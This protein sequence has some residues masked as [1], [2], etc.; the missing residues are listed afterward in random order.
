[1]STVKQRRLRTKTMV[2]RL[3]VIK[4]HCYLSHKDL[5][6]GHVTQVAANS[7]YN[8]VSAAFDRQVALDKRI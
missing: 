1:M 4:G 6:T 3:E 8:V 7:D 2:L 5:A